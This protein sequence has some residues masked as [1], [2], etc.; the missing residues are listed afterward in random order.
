MTLSG[1]PTIRLR[2][3]ARWYG[4]ILGVNRVDADLRPG[5]T[6]FLGPNGSG[7]ST[8]MNLICGLLRPGRGEV[9]IKGR[10]AWNDAASRRITGYCPQ[11]DSFYEH[12]T[13]RTFLEGLLGL[14]GRG[15]AWARRAAE[16]ALDRTGMTAHADRKIRAYSKGMRQRIK[17]A[18]ATAHDPEI[19][20]FDEPFNGLDPASRIEM[21][22]LVADYG[23]E[24]RTVL[25]S[26]H[27]LHELERMTDRV[28]MMSNGYVLAEGR[29]AEVREALNR[30]PF[31]IFMK[32]PDPRALAAALVAEPGVLSLAFEEEDGLRITTTEVERLYDRLHALAASG[33]AALELLTVADENVQSIYRYLSGREHH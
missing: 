1:E 6:G 8:L 12:M 25:V 28:L 11:Y 26:S 14:H 24:G 10:P 23:R 31:Q 32:S 5:V 16:T 18:L 7:K 27:I 3:V 4:E 2:G 15:R 20:I 33:E 22:D 13:G 29:V 19:L 9:L 17:V 30:H 21:M